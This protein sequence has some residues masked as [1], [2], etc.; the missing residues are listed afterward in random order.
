MEMILLDWTR[1]GKSYC[2]AGAVLQPGGVR[3]VRPLWIKFRHAPVHNV[4]WSAFL[5]DGYQRWDRFELVGAVPAETEPPHVED[6]WVRGMRPLRRPAT[7]AE[8]RLILEATRA[9]AE[10]PLF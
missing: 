7:L 10:G 8:R 4:G 9:P 2:L 1:I 5:M 3:I 6:L